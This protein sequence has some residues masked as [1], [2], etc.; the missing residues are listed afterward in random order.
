MTK[1][2]GWTLSLGDC[3][4]WRAKG[5]SCSQGSFHIYPINPVFVTIQY[6]FHQPS[7]RYSTIFIPSTTTVQSPKTR[8]VVTQ[9]GQAGRQTNL[10]RGKRCLSDVQQ[11]WQLTKLKDASDV[12]AVSP[13]ALQL[14]YL[15]VRNVDL[16]RVSWRQIFRHNNCNNHRHYQPTTIYVLSDPE[17]DFVG[18]KPHNRLSLP[19]RRCCQTSSLRSKTQKMAKKSFQQW[20]T[21]NTI[22][23]S[24]QKLEP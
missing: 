11:S 7:I 6:F 18:E 21:I 12:M 4:W 14:R 10:F 9:S 17:L 22:D 19:C 3:G 24:Q 2:L 13:S 1:K 20:S 16:F 15:Q 23:N 5:S 8:S